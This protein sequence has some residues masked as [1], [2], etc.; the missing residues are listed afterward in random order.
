[1]KNGIVMDRKCTD[2][3]MCIIFFLFF[4]GMFA[5]AAYGYAKG[6]PWQLITPFDSKSN[7]TNLINLGNKCGEDITTH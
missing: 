2:W 4:L 1:M 5:T 7:L 6:D 3:W